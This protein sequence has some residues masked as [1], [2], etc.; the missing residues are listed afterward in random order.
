MKKTASNTRKKRRPQRRKTGRTRLN[1][2]GM[3]TALVLAACLPLAG[4]SAFYYA[5]YS[6]LIDDRL[7]GKLLRVESRIF[8][9]PR[10]I[11]IGENLSP[12][13]LAAYLKSAGYTT[14]KDAEAAGQITVADSSIEIKPSENSYFAGKN[15]LA[16]DFA[17]RRIS[18]LRSLHGGERL[19]SA[20]IEPE[21]ITG[22]F[23]RSR[24]KRRMLR[25]E[26]IP[27]L[28]RKAVIITEDKRFFDHPG[29]D[30]IR[31]IGAAWVDVRRRELAQGAS[32]ITMQTARSFFFSTKRQWRRKIQETVMA[33]M[34]EHR[35]SKEQIFEL[36]ANE[37]YLGN[38]GSFAIHGFGEAAMAYFG[39]DLRELDLG[40]Y[41]F[42]AGIIHAPNRYSSS[43]RRP[44]RSAEAR[45]RVIALMENAGHITAVQAREAEEAPLG[46][47]AASRGAGSA[48]HFVDMVLEELSER[49]PE[50]DMEDGSYNIYT[51]L[52]TALQRAAIIA[53]DEG[54]KSID[55]R[56][57]KMPQ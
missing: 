21:I 17:H 55:A 46:L 45:D 43:E 48:G 53:V 27:P 14:V 11:A 31:I 51:T 56:L 49:F 16:V 36:Y 3:I 29:F 6:N 54:M 28:L 2:A 24:E 42:L 5:R 7:S 37:V 20:E 52:D 26:N 57:K 30:P 22:F 10:R 4:I 33:L 1:R 34:L 18:R 13:Q 41:C 39:K 9:A 19:M 12:D 32:T 8:S 23:D 40:Q 25:Y 47:I 15:A 38:R 35:F 50:S 44:E